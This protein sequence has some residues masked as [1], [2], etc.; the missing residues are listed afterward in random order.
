M[1]VFEKMKNR[2]GFRFPK[3]EPFHWKLTPQPGSYATNPRWSNRDL[4]PVPVR[5]R[6]WGIWDYFNYC[7]PILSKVANF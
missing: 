1:G 7:T 6:T 2:P 4:D 5:M 3:P